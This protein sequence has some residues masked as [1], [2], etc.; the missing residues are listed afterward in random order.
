VIVSMATSSDED[1]P[2]G[3]EFLLSPNRLNVA[4]SRAQWPATWCTVPSCSQASPYRCRAS[5]AWAHSS[6]S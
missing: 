2:R 5:S 1:L 6:N 4:V 3:I